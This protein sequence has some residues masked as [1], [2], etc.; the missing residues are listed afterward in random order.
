M[1]WLRVDTRLERCAS[2]RPAET[3]NLDFRVLRILTASIPLHKQHAFHNNHTVPVEIL[4][5]I[6]FP[7]LRCPKLEEKLGSVHS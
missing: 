4:L 5:F 3:T 2:R 7:I 6:L 1:S